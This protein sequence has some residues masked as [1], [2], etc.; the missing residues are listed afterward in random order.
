[1]ININITV[2]KN[3]FFSITYLVTISKSDL[4]E[5]YMKKKILITVLMIFTSIASLTLSFAEDISDRQELPPF[6]KGIPWKGKQMKHGFL[7]WTEKKPFTP[8]N[9]LEASKR[10][11]KIYLNNCMECHGISGTGEGPLTKKLNFKAANLKKVSKDFSN[12]YLAFQ[13]EAGNKD[14]PTWYDILT[15]EE[16]WDL[17]YYLRDLALKK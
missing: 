14:M 16:I 6:L 13:I 15:E 12:H 4:G 8:A 17:T 11:E 1:M 2:H 3:H 7:R 5:S 9:N 10:G